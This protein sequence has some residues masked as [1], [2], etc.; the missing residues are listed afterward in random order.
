MA[1]TITDLRKRYAPSAQR[2]RDKQDA[3]EQAK[4]L[5]RLQRRHRE[6]VAAIKRRSASIR[7][8]KDGVDATIPCRFCETPSR[9][10]V[11]ELPHVGTSSLIYFCPDCKIEVI[12]S[13]GD[14]EIDLGAFGCLVCGERDQLKVK[15]GGDA[16]L[17]TWQDF[18]CGCGAKGRYIHDTEITCPHCDATKVIKVSDTVF[19]GKPELRLHC[20]CGE[21]FNFLDWY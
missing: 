15:R 14:H 7:V 4:D 21:T 3:R 17:G 12:A 8:N 13:F 10:W 20:V 16:A 18:E 2:D 1:P 19:D 9:A 5:A 11:A 6:R